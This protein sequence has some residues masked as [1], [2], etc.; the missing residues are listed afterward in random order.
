MPSKKGKKTSKKATV[1][2]SHKQ[3]VRQSVVVNVNTR[4]SKPKKKD[5]PLAM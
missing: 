3:T 1:D 5:K 4:D 2:K